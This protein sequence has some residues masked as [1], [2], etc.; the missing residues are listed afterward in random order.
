[1]KRFLLYIC[2]G[3][4]FLPI[5]EVQGQTETFVNRLQ[6]PLSPSE[7]RY[8]SIQFDMDVKWQQQLYANPTYYELQHIRKDIFPTRTHRGV[9]ATGYASG[10]LDGDFL[11]F[12]GNSFEDFRIMAAG[13]YSI[14]S[15]GTLF[16]SVQYARGKHKNIGWNAVRYPELYQPYISTDSI[17]GDFHFED[18]RVSGGYSFH[19]DDLYLGVYGSF[20]G[21]QAYRKSDPRALNNTT[22][23]SLGIG[24]ARLFNDHLVML[25]AGYE[26]N[27]QHLS[28]RYWRPGQQD[29]FFVGY[30][31]GLYDVRL[32]AVAFGYSRMYYINQ[33][34]AR[35]AYQ[36]PMY[37]PFTIYAGLGY[38]YDYMKTEES[39]IRDLYFSK[40]HLF[41]PSIRLRWTPEGP[42][43]LSLYMENHSNKRKG[44][45]NIFE[46]YLA[47]EAN[48]IYD[49]RLIDTQQQYSRSESES[50]VQLKASFLLN[51]IHTFELIGG[52]SLFTREEKYKEENYQIKNNAILPHVGAGYKMRQ[53]KSEFSI[54]GLYIHKSLLDNEYNVV[55]KNQSIEHLDF[56]HAFMPYAYYNSTF[57]SVN[58]SATYVY[59]LKGYGIGIHLKGMYKQ[60]DRDKEAVYTG[61]IGFE[62]VAPHIK[63]TL[64]KHDEIW[65]SSTVF[66]VF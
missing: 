26:R 40:S 18:Y 55:M 36:S 39:D 6:V 62:S 57:S 44:Y 59:H 43:H 52:V 31:F 51:S 64:D 49:F 32:S 29:R 4:F 47:D 14:Q 41:D 23:L 42:V 27:K 8:N 10:E 21:E 9:V 11:P 19:L 66:F 24:A 56:Q 7:K 5:I 2:T 61:K 58:L 37:K 65:G 22:W 46:Q 3:L 1:M 33:G 30:G 13:E 34:S 28:L 54:S 60:G 48:N 35:I 17:G 45:E 16:G 53:K 63:T 20:H 12:E 15:A 25:Q 38:K 50:Q